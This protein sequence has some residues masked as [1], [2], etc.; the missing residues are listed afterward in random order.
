M[1]LISSLLGFKLAGLVA[2]FSENRKKSYKA[3]PTKASLDPSL[4]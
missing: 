1:F 2:V 4:F 3:L